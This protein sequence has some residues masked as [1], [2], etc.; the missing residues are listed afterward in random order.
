M[1]G[2]RASI[3]VVGETATRQSAAAPDDYTAGKL[4]LTGRPNLAAMRIMLDCYGYRIERLSDWPS[5][6]RDN[7]EMSE[8]NCQDYADRSRLTLRC[9]ASSGDSA[10]AL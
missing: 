6:L 2:R 7:A 4:V 5:L 9:V 8:S 1:M 10:T 3:Q